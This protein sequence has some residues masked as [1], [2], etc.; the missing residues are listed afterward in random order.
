MTAMPFPGFNSDTI[1]DMLV[2]PAAFADESIHDA[3]TTLRRDDPVH[4]TQPKGFR[5]F[6]SITRHADIVAISKANDR[7]INRERTYISP[8]E[9][10]E[11]VKSTTG[12]TCFARWSIWM[13]RCT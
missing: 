8:I 9:A 11:W 4:W 2:N 10:E 12:D 7:F 3:Y 1:D 13:T 5:P 6:W